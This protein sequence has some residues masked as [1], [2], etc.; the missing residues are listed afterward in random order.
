[1]FTNTYRL[2]RYSIESFWRQRLLSIATMMVILLVLLVF[3]GIFIF[4]SVGEAALTSIKE[5]IDVSVFFR[6]DVSEDNI[7]ALKGQIE[8]ELEEVREVTYISKD[9]AL[10]QFKEQI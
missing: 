4:G 5:K 8:R 1:M 10:N 3:Q 9:E 2:V 7:L 6:V